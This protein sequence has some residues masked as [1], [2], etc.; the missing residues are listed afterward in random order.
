MSL[1][2]SRPLCLRYGLSNT[3]QIAYSSGRTIARLKW[4]GL[5]LTTARRLVLL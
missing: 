4:F 1:N 5:P 3:P 2:L